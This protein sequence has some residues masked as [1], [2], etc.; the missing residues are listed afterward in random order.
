MEQLIYRLNL[1]PLEECIL[2]GVKEKYFND[3]SNPYYISI[4]PQTFF[5][6]EYL[7]L[8]NLNWEGILIFFRK[9]NMIGK[10]HT[11]TVDFDQTIWGINWIYNGCGLMEF[12][13]M[14]QFEEKDIHF[15]I[16]SQGFHTYQFNESIPPNVKYFLKPGAYLVNTTGPHRATGI[17]NRYCISYRQGNFQPSWKDVVDLFKDLIVDF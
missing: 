2:D 9:H 14:N 13:N 8:K 12:W 17:G 1:P 4:R 5:K 15:C 6:S 7:T 11:D 3:H 16:D 10:L